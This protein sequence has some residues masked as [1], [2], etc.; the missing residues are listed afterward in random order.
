MAKKQTRR[1]IS[2]SGTTYD[3]L[4]SASKSS[5]VPMARIAERLMRQYLDARSD[6]SAGAPVGTLGESPAPKSDPTY[7]DS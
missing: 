5:K 2:I 7:G 3:R 1:C 6:K 4:R